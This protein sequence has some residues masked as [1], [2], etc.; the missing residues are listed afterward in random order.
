[1]NGA[2]EFE[3][4]SPIAPHASATAVIGVADEP[5]LSVK[6]MPAGEV[7]NNDCWARIA[8]FTDAP[9]WSASPL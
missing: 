5:R 4:N 7:S 3:F 9:P 2:H 6:H 8:K 1:M